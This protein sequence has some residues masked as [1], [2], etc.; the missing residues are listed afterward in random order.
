MKAIS[1]GYEFLLILIEIHIMV[2]GMLLYRYSYYW[3]LEAFFYSVIYLMFV[4]L[5]FFSLCSSIKSF[6]NYEKL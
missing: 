3:S 2:I 6:T 4:F 5:L 1:Y